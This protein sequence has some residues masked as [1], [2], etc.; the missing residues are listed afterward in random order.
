MLKMISQYESAAEKHNEIEQWH[1]AQGHH[2]IHIGLLL[3]R[4]GI[5]GV[6]VA[7]HHIWL[8][9]NLVHKST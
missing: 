7:K 3:T 1:L 9:C 8:T 2:H 4:T 5:G 6:E